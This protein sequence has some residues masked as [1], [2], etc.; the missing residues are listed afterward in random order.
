MTLLYRKV[1]SWSRFCPELVPI[2]FANE[3]PQGVGV[4]DE[5]GKKA[6]TS[7]FSA[8]WA[9]YFVGLFRFTAN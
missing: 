9:T 5:V 2:R 7:D 1:K 6:G 4:E 3:F 8:D